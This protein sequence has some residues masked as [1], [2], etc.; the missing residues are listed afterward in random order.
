MER[1]LP[2]KQLKHKLSDDDRE[3]L[4]NILRLKF[5]SPD[6][7]ITI[8]FMELLKRYSGQETGISFDNS[9]YV[10]ITN[11]CSSS[12]EVIFTFIEFWINLYLTG[13]DTKAILHEIKQFFETRGLLYDIHFNN[14]TE[15]HEI[16]PV[17]SEQMRELHEQ[18]TILLLEAG[19]KNE[20]NKISEAISHLKKGPAGYSSSLKALYTALE[21]SI[22][23]TFSLLDFSKEEYD[24]K[25]ISPLIEL[26]RKNGFFKSAEGDYII[27]LAESITKM[28]AFVGGQRKEGDH[29]CRIERHEVLYSIYGV[30]N[31]IFY[32]MN[33]LKAKR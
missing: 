24:N 28:S 5:H 33:Q 21:I 2:E 15:H 4:K 14:D 17:A 8:A 18:V 19:W 7:S 13:V 29:Q 6:G 25:T 11:L 3:V 12:E 30:D 20:A 27:H 32:L 1:Y 23:H 22:K 9:E 16:Y 31:C 10:K 26:L